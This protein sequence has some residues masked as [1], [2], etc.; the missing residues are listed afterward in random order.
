MKQIISKASDIE[1]NTDIILET[2]DQTIK[3]LSDEMEQQCRDY[4]LAL[5][6]KTGQLLAQLTVRLQQEK[7]QLAADFE[8]EIQKQ[9]QDLDTY[10]Q[11][12]REQLAQEVFL[13]ILER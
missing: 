4:D 1:L 9:M 5:D 6:E 7:A 11:E 13:K 3:K 12:N 2:A 8:A 10:Y